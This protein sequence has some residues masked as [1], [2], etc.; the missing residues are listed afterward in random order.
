MKNLTENLVLESIESNNWK[1][2][3]EGREVSKGS[4]T[5]LVYWS[6]TSNGNIFA[7]ALFGKPASKRRYSRHDGSAYGLERV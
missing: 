3:D 4:T 2:D 5:L 7:D 6:P 1:H